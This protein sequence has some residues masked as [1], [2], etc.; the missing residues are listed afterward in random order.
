MNNTPNTIINAE[1]SV[2]I[3]RNANGV[4]D[5]EIIAGC[6]SDSF[7]EGLQQ[8]LFEGRITGFEIR[9]GN[10]NGGD[11]DIVESAGTIG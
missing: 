11:S 2:S 5:C 3:V 7:I 9:V 10:V 4:L 1:V 6:V 8:S